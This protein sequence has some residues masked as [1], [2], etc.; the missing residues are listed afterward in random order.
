MNLIMT[1]KNT[2]NSLVSKAQSGNNEAFGALFS[3]LRDRLAHFIQ[4]R[5]KPDYTERLDLE[6]ILQD[7]F[8]R[9]FQSIDRFRGD[10]EETFRRWLTGIANNAVLRAEDQARR[11]QTLEI[12]HELPAAS[13]SPSKALRR[14]ERFVR[15]QDSFDALTGDYREVIRLTRIEGLSIREAAK[16]MG[17]SKAAVKMLF[18]RAL[19]ELRRTMTDT[20]SLNL[21][22]RSLEDRGDQDAH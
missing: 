20:G 16:R 19:K 21:P 8:V 5:I 6:E 17:R 4:G 18:S 2:S 15:L 9:A 13:V 12:T 14:N 1:G 7:T 10:D 3:R 22:D 11:R